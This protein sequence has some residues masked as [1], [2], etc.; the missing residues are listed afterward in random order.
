MA[1]IVEQKSLLGE[2]HETVADVFPIGAADFESNQ[3]F[4]EI[5][6]QNAIPIG[7]RAGLEFFRRS[8]KLR[9]QPDAL[10]KV[11]VEV[12]V[13][14]TAYIGASIDID[15]DVQRACI[16]IA[17]QMQFVGIRAGVNCPIGIGHGHFD[18]LAHL[19]ANLNGPGIRN[20]FGRR[21]LL[22]IV[23]QYIPDRRIEIQ[24]D[25]RFGVCVS[26]ASIDV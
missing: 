24:D 13:F 12:N 8:G 18:H 17:Y 2:D 4:F 6:L 23:D 15:P 11:R 19:A 22:G 9:L 26:F 20:D 5:R 14:Q 3:V 7:V 21:L 10:P 16:Y 1:E 25:G